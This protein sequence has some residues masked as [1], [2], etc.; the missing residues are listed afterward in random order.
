MGVVAFDLTTW[1]ARYPEFATVADASVT[2]CFTE[3]TL[4]VSNRDSSPVVD[5]SVRATILNM[6]TAHV[7]A[8][9]FGVNGE[10]PSPLVGR[11]ESAAEG[12]VNVKTAYAAAA[13]SRAWWDQ[14]KYGAAAWQALSPFRAARYVPGYPRST[15]P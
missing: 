10:A 6:T 14:T 9:N 8:M 12:S 5:L 4:Y 2:A 13:G 1:R 7:V 11:I 3:A 15:W